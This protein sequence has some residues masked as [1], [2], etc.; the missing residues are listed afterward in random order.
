MHAEISSQISHDSIG[1]RQALFDEAN[2]MELLTDFKCAI[3]QLRS[4]LWLYIEEFCDRPNED[5]ALKTTHLLH[6]TEMLRALTQHQQSAS[7]PVSFFQEDSFFERLHTVMDAYAVDY[8][9]LDRTSGE[10]LPKISEAP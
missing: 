1:Q 6:A 3:D 4:V 9:C 2:A 8:H 10:D 7:R 5:P